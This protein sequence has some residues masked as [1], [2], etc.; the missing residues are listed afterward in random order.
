[1]YSLTLNRAV[2]LRL[3]GYALALFYIGLAIVFSLSPSGVRVG[4]LWALAAGVIAFVATILVHEWIH[5]LFMRLYGGAPRYGVGRIGIAFY[6]YATAPS[7]PFTLMQMTVICLAPLLL[8]SAAAFTIAWLVPGGAALAALAFVT[9]LSGAAGDMWMVVQM[10]RFRHCRDL[11][12]VDSEQR[13]DIHTPDPRASAVAAT[14]AARHGG[15][16]VPRIL[17]RWLLAS[18]LIVCAV[19][20][21]SVPLSMSGV[22]S[23]SLG[24]PS[25]AVAVYT[26]Q[27]DGGFSMMLDFGVVFATGLMYALISVAF[28]RRA[29]GRAPESTPPDDAPHPALV[30]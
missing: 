6:A 13:L 7:V 23:M 19:V 2:A 21:L 9:N 17:V 12:L 3:T 8:I 27:P 4:S 10:W 26:L 25:F 15:G 28:T 14:L 11:R 16:V 24:P 20:L 22:A 18:T 30:V 29:G 5:G 1:V